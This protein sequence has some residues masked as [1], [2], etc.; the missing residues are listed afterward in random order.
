MIVQC[1]TGGGQKIVIMPRDG[2]S[3]GHGKLCL[4]TVKRRRGSGSEKKSAQAQRGSLFFRA[5]S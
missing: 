1:G 5:G 4:C 3:G 2:D